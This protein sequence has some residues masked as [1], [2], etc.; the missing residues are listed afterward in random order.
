M[1]IK[2]RLAESR[3]AD[4]LQSNHWAAAEA[5]LFPDTNLIGSSI[6]FAV[7]FHRAAAVSFLLMNTQ[8]TGREREATTGQPTSHI[9]SKSTQIKPHFQSGWYSL[10]QSMSNPGGFN[11]WTRRGTHLITLSFHLP[12]PAIKSLYWTF[13]TRQRRWELLHVSSPSFNLNHRR[14]VDCSPYPSDM[15]YRRDTLEILA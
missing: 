4:R 14:T 13:Q 2:L 10:R 6:W 5:C 15:L 9:S 12:F 11:R 3:A 1:E 8:T 7:S